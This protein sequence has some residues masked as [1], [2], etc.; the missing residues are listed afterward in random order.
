MRLKKPHKKTN[1]E[2]VI[3]LI[4]VVLLMLIFFLI[5]GTLKP[6]SIADIR[7]PEMEMNEKLKHQ[8]VKLLIS[9]QGTILA[10]EKIIEKDDLITFLSAQKANGM[11]AV[12]IIADRRLSAS[13][14]IEII[15]L[16]KEAQIDTVHI[17]AKRQK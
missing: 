17:Y 12:S 11:T 3:P 4:N 9:E 6:F 10:N 1:Q 7:L 16:A 8:D 15:E 13:I 2:N 5:A 14:F